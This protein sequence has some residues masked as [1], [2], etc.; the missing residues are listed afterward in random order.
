MRLEAIQKSEG[1][2]CSCPTCGGAVQ[3]REYGEM[4]AGSFV[5]DGKRV[6]FSGKPGAEYRDPIY[7]DEITQYFDGGLYR[8]WPNERYLSKGGGRLHRDVWAAAFGPIPA[9]CHIHHKDG[10]VLNNQL[11]NLECIDSGEHLSKHWAEGKS[12]KRPSEHFTQ[13]ARD[14]AAEWHS[15]PEGRLWH[16]R[17]AKRSKGWTKWKREPKPCEHCGKEFMALVRKSG[18]AGKYCGSPCKAAAYRERGKSAEYA[19]KY[20]ERQKDKQD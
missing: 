2:S 10:D 1:D 17:N 8:M 20:R 14:K 9:G 15:S 5:S 13:K 11:W 6:G 19:R 12:H 4:Y 7:L 3:R 18:N 16:S